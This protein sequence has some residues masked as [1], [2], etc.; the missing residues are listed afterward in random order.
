VGRDMHLYGLPVTWTIESRSQ[1]DRI[2]FMP[3]KPTYVIDGRNFTTLENFYEEMSRVIFP[4]A[5]WGRNL[6]AFNDILRR[7]FG[8]PDN[9][10]SLQWRH[11][12]L[13]RQRLSYEETVRQLEEKLLR[14][15]STARDAVASELEL[16][17]RNEGP[18]VFDWLV[19]IIRLH[20]EGGREAQDNVELLLQ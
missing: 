15:N 3:T 1:D 13:S 9:G 14:C 17:R 10:F 19:D 16:A 2:L 7:G 8:T 11:S 12:E 20:C 18:T 5:E 6:D 4:R